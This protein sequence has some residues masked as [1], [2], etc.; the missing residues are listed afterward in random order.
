M[1]DR[2]MLSTIG[3]R[4]REV[5][6]THFRNRAEAAKAAGVAKSTFQNWVEGKSD[7]SFSGLARLAEEADFS[8][9]WLAF[10]RMQ[11]SVEDLG[12]VFKTMSLFLRREG[13]ELEPEHFSAACNLLLQLLASN[14]DRSSDTVERAMA[15]IVTLIR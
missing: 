1:Q 7:P 4:L 3:D 9:D 15:Q 11:P 10:G 12:H 6:R 13:L 14:E 5:E 8:L 2:D